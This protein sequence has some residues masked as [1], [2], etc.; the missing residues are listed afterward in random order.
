MNRPLRNATR[1]VLR[2]ALTVWLLPYC[3]IANAQ[4]ES[5]SSGDSSLGSVY[6][7][8]MSVV[9]GSASLYS[10]AEYTA[11]YPGARGT[12][13]FGMQPF[14]KGMVNYK[15]VRYPGV[16]MAYDMVAGDLV[17]KSFNGLNM[18]LPARSVDSFRIEGHLFIHLRPDSTTGPEIGE[19][20]FELLAGRKA[21][22]LAR[23]VR[24]VERGASAEEPFR[25]AEYTA[26]FVR[27]DG[28]YYRID[29]KNDLKQLYGSR[30]ESLRKFWKSAGIQR[31]KKLDKIILATF[32]HYQP[33]KP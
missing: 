30:S 2:T 12:P 3:S 1:N 8:Y 17:I 24:Q 7:I 4:F 32:A 26:F 15:G 31:E 22:V 21:E 14:E 11:T 6:H 33:E 20:F 9:G 25:F 18:I 29:K 23:R 19:G 28:K 5:V 16:A 10:G 13:F 27:K